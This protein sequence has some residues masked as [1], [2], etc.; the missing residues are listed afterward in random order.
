M[1]VS[2]GAQNAG[3]NIIFGNNN[4]VKVDDFSDTETVYDE[5]K[6]TYTF[7]PAGNKV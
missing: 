7:Y 2:A 1:F 6:K 4:Q 3:V 5:N